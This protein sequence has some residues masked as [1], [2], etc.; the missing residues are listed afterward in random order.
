V[1]R[2]LD[3]IFLRNNFE[4]VLGFVDDNPG[5]TNKT[6]V[7]TL[8]DCRRWSKRNGT[9]PDITH[10]P[11]IIEPWKSAFTSFGCIPED[12]GNDGADGGPD[13]VL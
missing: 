9:T 11:D 10:V 7:F 5:Q 1:K 2:T 3:L 8:A 12:A 13:D 6:W 4:C